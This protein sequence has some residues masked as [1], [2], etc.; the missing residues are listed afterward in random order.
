[1]WSPS[2]LALRQR[3]EQ[4]RADALAGHVAGAARAEAAAAAVAGAGKRPWRELEVL[5]RVG[6]T[7]HAAGQRRLA[8]GLAQR[9]RTAR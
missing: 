8:L 1:M 4:H 2:A 7:V 9:A 3:L 5:V 6:W